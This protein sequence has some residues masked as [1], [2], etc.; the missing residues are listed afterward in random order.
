MSLFARNLWIF[1]G[2]GVIFT[3]GYRVALGCLFSAW[4]GCSVGAEEMALP[5]G[6]T[7]SDLGVGFLWGFAL[8][9]YYL[10]QKIW[11]VRSDAA[12]VRDLRLDAPSVAA[13]RRAARSRAG[14]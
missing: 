1:L 3:V 7:M 2:A 13:A 10:D 5:A 8:H 9:H 6:L 4:P 12:L 14:S 11:H